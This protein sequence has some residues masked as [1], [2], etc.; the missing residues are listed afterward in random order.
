MTRVELTREDPGNFTVRGLLPVQIPLLLP[1]LRHYITQ[2]ALQIT[3][4][5]FQIDLYEFKTQK[6]IFFVLIVKV[7]EKKL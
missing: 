7:V 4:V 1:E 2:N 3:V 6:T 5:F